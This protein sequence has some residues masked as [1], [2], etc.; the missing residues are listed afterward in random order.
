MSLLFTLFPA[1][2]RKLKLFT[3]SCCKEYSCTLCNFYQIESY[4][5]SSSCNPVSMH[6]VGTL[7]LLYFKEILPRTVSMFCIMIYHIKITVLWV[8][9]LKWMVTSMLKW[10]ILFAACGSNCKKCDTEGANKCDEGQCKASAGG[11]G[12]IWIS[13][14]KTCLGKC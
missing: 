3:G 9:I 2:L 4:H 13:Q 7:I 6:I 5:S 12:A 1:N 10:L 8:M 11:V 14:T